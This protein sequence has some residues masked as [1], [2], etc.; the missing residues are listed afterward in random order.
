M[1]RTGII[2][3]WRRAWYDQA[4]YGWTQTYRAWYPFGSWAYFRELVRWLGARVIMKLVY[5]RV[6][7]RIRGW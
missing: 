5:N 7:R 3:S 6:V 1:N 4:G 2:Q